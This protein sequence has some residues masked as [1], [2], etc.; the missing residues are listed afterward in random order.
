M[1]EDRRLMSI[2]PSRNRNRN[3]RETFE[4]K[5]PYSVSSRYRI[6]KKW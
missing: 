3:K 6:L 4:L 2:L 5:M 1:D